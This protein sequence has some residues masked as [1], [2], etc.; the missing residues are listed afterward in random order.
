[1]KSLKQIAI[2]GQISAVE[3]RDGEFDIVGIE[4]LAFGKCARR[5]AELQP[6]VPHFLREAAD[7]V[8]ES[9]FGAGAGMQKKKIDIGVGKEPSPSESA[10]CNQ[11]ET[12]GPCGIG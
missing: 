8:F 5:R 4:A 3:Q 2:T 11:G 6:Q 10:G 7:G 12:L 9:V 1:M